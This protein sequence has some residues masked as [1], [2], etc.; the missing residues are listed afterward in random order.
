MTVLALGEN[1]D[2]FNKGCFCHP[3]IKKMQ[4]NN[5]NILAF[6]QPVSCADGEDTIVCN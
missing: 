1:L 2:R 3:E 5:E 4:A 6:A